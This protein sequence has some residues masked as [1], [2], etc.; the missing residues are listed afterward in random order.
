MSYSVA[1]VVFAAGLFT[2]AATVSYILW[3]Y[4]KFR[5]KDPFEGE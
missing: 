3:G 5:D 1:I 2:A 4:L